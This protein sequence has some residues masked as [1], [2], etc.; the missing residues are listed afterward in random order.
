M[1]SAERRFPAS[2]KLEECPGGSFVEDIDDRVAAERRE[3]LHLPFERAGE[4]AGERQEPL[5]VRAREIGDRDQVATLGP[6]RRQELVTDQ[7]EPVDGVRSRVDQ[8]EPFFSH[9]ASLS[10]RRAGRG[11]PRRPRRAAPGCARLS[12]SEGSCRRSRAGWAAR[13]GPGRRDTRAVHGPAGRIRRASRSPRGSCGPCRGRRR[14]GRTSALRAG[15][16][17]A[18]P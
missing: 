5:D 9:R 3:L 13:G 14:R 16:R 7:R 4:V 11:R 6:A 12:Q 17:A 2:S 18:S 15:T 1:T 10:R 8:A